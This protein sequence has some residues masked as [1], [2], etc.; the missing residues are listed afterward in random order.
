MHRVHDTEFTKH[1]LSRAGIGYRQRKTSD[2]RVKVE[3]SCH[4]GLIAAQWSE[5]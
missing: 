3:R 5:R 4:V 2:L 1:P